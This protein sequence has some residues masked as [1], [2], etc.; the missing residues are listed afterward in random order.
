MTSH[1]SWCG[2][3]PGR[4][5]QM[6]LHETS[7]LKEGMPRCRSF[8]PP[9]TA[10]FASARALSELNLPREPLSTAANTAGEHV[11]KL[12]S[13]SAFSSKT[14]PT[15]V[16]NAG[17]QMTYVGEDNSL[18]GWR[19]EKTRR[20][21]DCALPLCWPRHDPVLVA[22]SWFSALSGLALPVGFM[23]RILAKQV[24]VSRERHRKTSWFRTPILPEAKRPDTGNAAHHG[25][26]Q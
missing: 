18:H 1:W 23:S 13:S 2:S 24:V 9:P 25:A 7:R 22:P 15:Y 14:K 17:P 10:V 20:A 5:R 21:A 26:A 8:P 4:I 19:N 6:P 11:R 16:E 12:E 3:Q